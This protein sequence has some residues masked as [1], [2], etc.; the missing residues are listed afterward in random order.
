MVDLSMR[1]RRVLLDHREEVVDR[2]HSDRQFVSQHL[3]V[4]FV[5]VVRQDSLVDGW[6]PLRPPTLPSATAAQRRRESSSIT[7]SQPD[8]A[9]TV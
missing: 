4:R 3:R 9:K 7:W 2:S 8:A 5:G 6:H 1:V